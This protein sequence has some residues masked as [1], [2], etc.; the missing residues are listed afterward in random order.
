MCGIAGF[1]WDDKKLINSMLDSLSKRGPDES[2]F[3]IDRGIS[4]GTRRLSVI[5]LSKKG[6]QPIS[7][8]DGTKWIAYNG[9]IYNFKELRDEL[10]KKGHKFTSGT[11]TEVI[12]HS[13]EEYGKRCV[14][15]FNGMFAFA[16]WD[17]KKKEL[18][19]ARDRLGVKPLFYF[20]DGKKFAFASE[21]KAIL[22]YH[23]NPSIDEK[24]I[25]FYLNYGYTPNNKTVFTKIFK[26]PAGCT[27]T[28]K[29][30][31]FKIEKYWKIDFSRKEDGSEDYFIKKIREHME[32]SVKIRLIA[33]VPVGAFLSGGLDSSA[34]VAYISKHKDNLK[35]FSV[36]FEHDKFD[37]SKYAKIVSE[38]FGTEHHQ[39]QFTH[40]NVIKLLPKLV[41][42]YDEPFGDPSMMPTYLVSTVARK[43]VTVSLSGDGGDESFLGYDRY[44]QY[45]LINLQNHAPFLSKIANPFIKSLSK[46]TNHNLIKK[47][48]KYLEFNRLNGY[49]QYSEL[50]SAFGS[51][52]RKNLFLKNHDFSPYFKE[53]F[54]FKNYL[55]N[56]SNADINTYLPDDILTKLDRSTMMVSLEGRVPFLDY[57]FMEFSAKI[58]ARLKLKGME[59]KYILKKSLIGILPREI[60]YRKK[61]GFS[62]PLDL[63]IKNE[64]KDL[65]KN[66]LS[67]KSKLHEYVDKG[68]IE[69]L[70][71]L[72]YNNEKNYANGLWAIFILKLWLDMY[73]KK[74][75]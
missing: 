35:T 69:K 29:N 24:S 12:I 62:F 7:N 41:D 26:L 40:E 20:M 9:E 8:E 27:L 5:D 71:R 73:L 32:E 21:I 23:K 63:Y 72:H 64:L 6:K 43:H 50:R 4:M 59:T 16:V 67:E 14:E 11:D 51:D 1:N 70:L 39:M 46:I 17:T 10:Q 28:F 49:E 42:Y 48:G 3:Y 45:R 2:G 18:F 33:D 38:K 34:I 25:Y 74:Y 60:I 22:K 55:D 68:H 54:I 66:N 65:V 56:I 52:E 31:E 58:P 36:G 44:K 37:E 30:S 53:F 13:Y 47:T 15:K 61:Q 19:I 57:K 75:N